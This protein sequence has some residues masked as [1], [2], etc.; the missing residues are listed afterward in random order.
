[1]TGKETVQKEK[2][3]TASSRKYSLLAF[4]GNLRYGTFKIGQDKYNNKVSL[5]AKEKHRHLKL[6]MGRL[7]SPE[8]IL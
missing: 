5:K 6:G 3:R 1:M 2:K 4:Y 8:I 7:S